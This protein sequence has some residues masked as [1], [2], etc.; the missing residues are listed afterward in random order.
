MIAIPTQL[1]ITVLTRLAQDSQMIGRLLEELGSMP[2]IPITTMEGKHFGAIL[3]MFKAGSFR[4]IECLVIVKF[5]IPAMSDE[6][7]AVSLR[8]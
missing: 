7:G 3:S 4:E 1:A 6:L 8:C 2:N 5:S